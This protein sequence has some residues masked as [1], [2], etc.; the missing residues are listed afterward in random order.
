ML[1][2]V[3]SSF[4]SCAPGDC[5]NR[6]WDK[7]FSACG[8]SNCISSFS[9]MLDGTCFQAL[10]RLKYFCLSSNP[11]TKTSTSGIPFNCIIYII[12]QMARFYIWNEKWQS[13]DEMHENSIRKFTEINL[14]MY[15]VYIIRMWNWFWVMQL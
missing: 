1:A 5:C 8:N 4:L 7:H 11:I 12:I 6:D 14:R 9:E 3:R 2:S 15:N 10:D 13:F